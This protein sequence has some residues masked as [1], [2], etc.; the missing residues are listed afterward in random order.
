MGAGLSVHSKSWFRSGR[1]AESGGL[2]PTLAKP[3][4][5]GALALSTGV[6]VGGRGDTAEFRSSSI[7]GLKETHM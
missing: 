4:L 5:L 6:E 7:S 3:L 2:G 1:R